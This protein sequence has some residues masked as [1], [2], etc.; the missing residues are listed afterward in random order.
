MS[1]VTRFICA[2]S[3]E[4]AE[5]PG[6]SAERVRV[7]ATIAATCATSSPAPMWA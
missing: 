5:D 4:L 2:V 7:P 3:S 6:R 1:Q